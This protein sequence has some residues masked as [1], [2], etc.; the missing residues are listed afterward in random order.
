MVVVRRV[1]GSS[2]HLHKTEDGDWEWSD[3]EMDEKSEEGKA[4]FSQEKSRRVKE[5]NTEISMNSRN[6]PDQIQNLSLQGSQTRTAVCN[7]YSD[8]PCAVNL[9]LRLRITS[10]AL[11]I[12]PVEENTRVYDVY[13]DHAFANCLTV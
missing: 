8:A 10:G 4:A 7:E 2:G 12:S 11:G 1:P 6:I 13:G 5:E 9:V 3:D